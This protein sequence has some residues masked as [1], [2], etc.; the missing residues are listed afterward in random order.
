MK[1]VVIILS[2]IA[3]IVCLLVGL[4]AGTDSRN[5]TGAIHSSESS[6]I[7]PSQQRTLLIIFTDDIQ[8]PSARLA[9]LW[10][11]FYRPDTPRLVV[12]PLYPLD[13]SD[14][15]ANQFTLTSSHI[16]S[17][18][19]LKAVQGY[20]FRWDGY[21]LAD[22][23]MV[24]ALVDEFKGIFLLD[25]P[26]NG[27]A[28]AG[29]LK[30]P[31][32]KREEALFSQEQFGA[33]F[34]KLIAAQTPDFNVKKLIARLPSQHFYIEFNLDQANQDWKG[35]AGHGSPIQCEF[36]HPSIENQGH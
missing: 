18:S 30:M 24:P 10:I 19:F 14:D 13:A 15:L 3:F 32:E 8:S 9:G 1:A 29:T 21:V 6:P 4:Q 7:P 22:Q 35:L 11:V 31:W 17:P 27:K 33:A 2:I 20:D 16:P 36:P 28:A 23:A 34:C 25:T 5:V 26:M 12:M